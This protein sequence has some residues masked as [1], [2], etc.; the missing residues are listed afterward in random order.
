MIDLKNYDY[1]LP[2]ELIAQK[3]A[4]P[5][6]SSKLLVLDT[7]KDKIYIDRFY[8]FDQYLP[9]KSFLVLNNTKVLPARVILYKKT[10]GKVKV[11]LLVNE[12]INSDSNIVK[13]LV[14]RSVEVGNKLFFDSCHSVTV[15]GQQKKIFYLRLNFPRNKFFQLLNQKG[16]MP[17]PLY[18]KETPLKERD[19]RKKYQT[20]FAKSLLKSC[21][22]GSVAAPTASL[23]FTNR[24]FKKIEKRGIEKFFITLYVGLGTFSPV[25]KKNIDEKKL[26]KEYYEIEKQVTHYINKMS[27]R[28]Y[29]LV[30]VGTTVVRALESAAKFT[31]YSR[32]S[33]PMQQN[34]LIGCSNFTDLFIYPPYNFKM[35]DILLT[36]FH[37]PKSSLMMLVDA[38]LRYKKA[39]RSIIDLYQ[40]AI[41]NDFRFY[42]FGDAMLIL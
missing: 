25:D 36:N 41:K 12:L 2:Q 33:V 34:E 5:R 14:D 31:K 42:S 32:L 7:K 23:H 15:V 13:T 17:I 9:Q 28:G 3:P 21:D 8:N 29:Q 24:V 16:K 11:L 22:A 30:V 35:V 4:V 10:G 18:I 40:I 19:L 26:H 39:K 20:I 27:Q 1:N 37:L 38:F 6:D